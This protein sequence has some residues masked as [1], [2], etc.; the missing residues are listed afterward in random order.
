[1][2]QDLLERIKQLELENE[3]LKTSLDAVHGSSSN[4]ESA[5][6]V[7]QE[8]NLSQ[9]TKLNNP[10]HLTL[11]EYRRYGRQMI[12]PEFGSLDSQLKLKESKILVIGAGGLGCP[13][14]LY[15]SAAG[16][17]TIGIV[18][19]DEVD[20]SNLHRQ[21]LHTTK[22]VG[23]AKCES[24]KQYIQMLNP[25][26]NVVSYPIR[27]N[28]SNAFDVIE[29]YDLVLDCTDAP[30]IRYLINDVCVLLSK[31][32]VSGSGLKTDG[33]WTILNFQLYG[34]CYRCFHPKPPAEG[35]ITSCQDGGV[36]GPA[37]GLIGISMALETIKVLT[38]YYTK[39]NFKP[40]LCCFFGYQ[41]QQYR[42]FKMRNRQATC[43]V[44][45]DSPNIT[46]E[47]IE[48]N[49]IDYNEFCG[50]AVPYSL[51][52]NLRVSV[53]EFNDHLKTIDN[54]NNKTLLLDVRPK[55]QFNIA[56]LPNFIN[57][58]WDFR[59]IKGFLFDELIPKDFNKEKDETFVIC[60]YGNDSQMATRTLI[61]D[62]GFHNVKDIRGGLNA[63]SI[64]VDNTV[65]RY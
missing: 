58:P 9:D 21:V 43:Q 44:C 4:L 37:I 2:S 8:R 24:A 16:V 28:N 51:N 47:A 31:T 38:G 62:Y 42:V 14:L 3:K 15:L 60:R 12:V 61:D 41:F 18:D 30:A 65:P 64:K 36:I 50:Q 39:D 48:S 35:S 17:G 57:V 20:A 25:N 19:D 10:S 6:K 27:L 63:W 59:S 26:V 23:M 45:G 54:N 22:S 46:K 56:S 49:L 13:A 34:P 53:N 29:P 1:M 33:Q 40:F 52:S 7:S 5:S 55:E 32:I 11:E